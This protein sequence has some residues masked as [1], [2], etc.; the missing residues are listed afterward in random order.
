MIL[1]GNGTIEKRVEAMKEGAVDFA[2]KPADIG[3]QLIKLIKISIEG[4]FFM[5]K[6]QEKL[7]AGI[8]QSKS[9]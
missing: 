1:K 2:K 5:E 6:K 3:E 4:H 7:L 9:W 8:L